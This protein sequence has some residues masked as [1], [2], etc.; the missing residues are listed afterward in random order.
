LASNTEDCEVTG[1]AQEKWKKALPSEVDFWQQMIGGTFPNKDWIAGLRQRLAGQTPF[2]EHLR[3]YMP[4]HG[5]V[6][7]LDVGAGPATVIGLQGAPQDLE[8]VAIDPLADTYN[9]LLAKQGLVPAIRTRRGEGERLSELD[10][11]TFDLVYSRN[12][13]DHAYEPLKVIREML[14]AAKTTGAVFFEGAVN[15]GC[16]QSYVGLHQWN[17]MPTEDGDLIVWQKNN[18][19]HSLRARLGDN[20]QVRA[21]AVGANREWYQVEI[22]VTSF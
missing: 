2:P 18:N 16:T 8:I 6:R 21:H 10:L 14:S 3:K 13:L 12:A 11:G 19:A 5:C 7:L 22:K 20:F 17:F 1:E 15:E 4:T 9:D